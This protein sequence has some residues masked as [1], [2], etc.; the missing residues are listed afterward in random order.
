MGKT[1]NEHVVDLQTFVNTAK[2]AALRKLDVTQAADGGHFLFFHGQ[3]AASPEHLKSQI[4]QNLPNIKIVS[5][6]S[7]EGQAVLIARTTDNITQLLG[8]WQ[9][10]TGDNLTKAAAKKKEKKLDLI[11][12]RGTVGNIGQVLMILSG[13]FDSAKKAGAA[14]TAAKAQ[15]IFDAG[16]GGKVD[17]LDKPI[18]SEQ[19]RIAKRDKD[20]KNVYQTTDGVA[21]IRSASLSFIGNGVNSVYGVQKKEDDT[22]LTFA[23]N[24]VNEVL[25]FTSQPLP[26]IEDRITKKSNKYSWMEQNSFVFSNA[27]KFA[28]K[29][30][31]TM[32]GNKQLKGHG[33]LSLAAKVVTLT[34]KPE[35]PHKLEQDQTLLT[36]TRRQSNA[37]A[38]IMEWIANITLWSG[39][40]WAENKDKIVTQP[41][42]S[43]NKF[44]GLIR[45]LGQ[46]GKTLIRPLFDLDKSEF[47]KG[48]IQW[49]Q[50][51]GSLTIF[52]SLTAKAMAPF[53]VKTIDKNEL[54]MH[55]TMA[56]ASGVNQGKHSDELARLSSQI[57]QTR[58]L[59][60]LKDDG[61][62]VF[63]TEVANRLEQHH[64]IAIEAAQGERAPTEMIADAPTV[65]PEVIPET[66]PET[67]VEKKPSVASTIANTEREE[68]LAARETAKQEA[69]ETA[70][71]SAR[72]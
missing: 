30:A 25:N 2:S 7:V 70:V 48:N 64:G 3:Q 46:Y 43:K 63:F 16:K 5:S 45:G 20:A 31:M 72:V 12:V 15:K 54:A 22:R 38:G 53:A 65:A 28:G 57:V 23:K 37:I 47:R 44:I 41:T 55:A 50:L 6:T 58:E 51:L 62:S 18:T 67:T 17:F 42:E 66:T 14:D 39:S 13:F 29:L 60:E 49:F 59:K 21:K 1:K 4:E 56:L 26:N 71:A 35:D 19:V 68:N 11:K 33:Y 69:A 34:G 9:S 52:G 8:D 32:A 61:F 40:L 36:R 27:V 10:A 24:K